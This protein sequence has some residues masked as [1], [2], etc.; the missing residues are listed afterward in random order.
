LKVSGAAVDRERAV[1][2]PVQNVAWPLIGSEQ[3][4][5]ESGSGKEDRLFGGG[6]AAARRAS[7]ETGTCRRL[8][9]FTASG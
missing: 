2:G 6:V 1:P 3:G 4:V 8:F 9:G 5:N 7:L